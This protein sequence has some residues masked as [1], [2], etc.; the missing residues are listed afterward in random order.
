[1]YMRCVMCVPNY[2]KRGLLKGCC[3]A[4][5]RCW[6][7]VA[8]ITSTQQVGVAEWTQS[9]TL[10]CCAPHHDQGLIA[11]GILH[12][13]RSTLHLLPC[14]ASGQLFCSSPCGAICCCSELAMDCTDQYVIPVSYEAQHKSMDRLQPR[15]A[16]QQRP[17]AD[18]LSAGSLQSCLSRS[19]D[20][21]RLRVLFKTRTVQHQARC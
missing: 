17:P 4:A 15:P 1:M 20:C 6:Q 5:N 16:A 10:L 13:T 2:R 18:R 7:E 19:G 12:I 9:S 21:S 11:V 8:Q 3:A 14:A